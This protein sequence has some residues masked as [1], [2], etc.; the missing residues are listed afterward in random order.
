M[1]AIFEYNSNAKCSTKDLILVLNIYLNEKG[2]CAKIQLLKIFNDHYIAAKSGPTVICYTKCPLS[3]TLL[4]KFYNGHV[5]CKPELSYY[6][7]I[8]RFQL[9]FAMFC[10]KG[11]FV[12][13]WDYLNYPNVLVGS[14]SQFHLYLM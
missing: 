3:F 5:K 6:F 14:V 7:Q 2:P 11:T 10:A 8:Y 13:S 12:I 9:N 4:T 1:N